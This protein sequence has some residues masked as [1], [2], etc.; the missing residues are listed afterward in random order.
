M[1][2][3]HGKIAGESV[4][5]VSEAGAFSPEQVSR[6]T[7]LSDRQ[8][9]YW[10]DTE[11]FSPA[12]REGVRRSPYARV[13]AFRDVVGLRVLA[14]LR[15][16][17]KVPLQTLRK[18]GAY[19]RERFDEPWSLLTFYVVGKQVYYQ[20]QKDQAIKR[21]DE[22]G[23]TVM[24]VHVARVESD[25]RARLRELRQRAPEQVGTIER[26]RYIADNQYVIGGTRI[27]TRAI[28][29]FDQAGYSVNGILRQYPHLKPEDV[30]AAIDF[31]R[32]RRQRAS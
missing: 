7:G 12:F 24:D 30:R 14:V 32:G 29:E 2:P 10:D 25:V 15:N 20:D 8:L 16:T 18:V 27:P 21:A 19:L 17:Y 28:W 9:R 6:L 11:F 22:T 4:S 5:T 3:A 26:N 31:E 1:R 13:Y 23:Q